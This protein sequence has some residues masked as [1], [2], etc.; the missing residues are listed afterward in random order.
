MEQK[1]PE[2]ALAAYRRSLGLYPKR[3]NSVLGAARAARAAGH[4]SLARAFYKELLEIADGRTSRLAR[5]EAPFA[6]PPGPR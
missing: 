1:Q 5:E 2:E 3:F 6:R 4:E